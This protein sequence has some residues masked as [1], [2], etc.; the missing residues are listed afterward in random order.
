MFCSGPQCIFKPFINL[1][2]VGGGCHHL[3]PLK[4]TKVWLKKWQTEEYRHFFPH[5]K[6]KLLT[7]FDGFSLWVCQNIT[8]SPYIFCVAQGW[9]ELRYSCGEFQSA[10]GSGGCIAHLRL[11]SLSSCWSVHSLNFSF[12]SDFTVLRYK[13]F[14]VADILQHA[15]CW[16]YSCDVSS[17]KCKSQRW[18]CE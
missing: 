12:N 13:S 9:A 1:I 11:C 16:W 7:L 17:N 3:L 10:A 18:G 4:V 15:N 8:S 2:T 14:S 5:F 6:R